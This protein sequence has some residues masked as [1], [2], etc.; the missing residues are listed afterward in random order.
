VVMRPI[1]TA[2]SMRVVG[3][4]A[5]AEKR[6][7]AFWLICE[8]I[9]DTADILVRSS[10]LL[11]SKREEGGGVSRSGITVMLVWGAGRPFR[12]RACLLE[13]REV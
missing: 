2:C 1:E 6:R 7:M 3:F 8:V 12:C 13:R 5:R 9:V 4:E 11:L 10:F